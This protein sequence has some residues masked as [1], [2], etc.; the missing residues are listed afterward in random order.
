MGYPDIQ[1]IKDELIILLL[2]KGESHELPL[3]IV[4]TELAD[5]F[6]LTEEEKNAPYYVV[7]PNS[8]YTEN[9]WHNRIRTAKARLIDEEIL[10]PNPG[11]AICK[12]HPSIDT[13]TLY[14]QIINKISINSTEFKSPEE[15]I[16]PQIIYEGSKRTINVNIYERNPK[17]R[18]ICISHYGAICNICNFNFIDQYGEIGEG[19]IHVHHLTP[20]SEIN[21]NYQINPLE[22]LLPVCPN[23][24]AMIHRRTPPLT[25]DEIK[26]III[27][28]MN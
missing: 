3:Q 17:A 8:P 18:Q 5:V 12:I 2:K 10:H 24:H 9:Y 21:E 25:I 1:E 7:Q 4:Y 26:S 28:N 19:F 14:K 23:C 27:S 6:K 13:N 16:N 22:D 20:L 15:I 11:R